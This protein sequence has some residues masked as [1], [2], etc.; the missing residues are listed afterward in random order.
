[1]SE[2]NIINFTE[3]WFDAHP[4]GLE[5][6]LKDAWKHINIISNKSLDDLALSY[7]A[8]FPMSS[9]ILVEA[10]L[11][12]DGESF[13]V[14]LKKTN[15]KSKT[16]PEALRYS[17]NVAVDHGILRVVNIKGKGY[18]KFFLTPYGKLLVPYLKKN[19]EQESIAS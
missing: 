10:D 14:I 7:M 8:S 13:N 5:I 18:Q 3:K 1:M 19:V 16:P 12:E 9:H 6:S 2:S 11:D 4:E 15:R 17:L